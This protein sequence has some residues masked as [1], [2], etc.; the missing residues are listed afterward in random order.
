MS[1]TL[2]KMFASQNRKCPQKN[3]RACFCAKC[4]LPSI[5][6]IILWIC[7]WACTDSP[8]KSGSRWDTTIFLWKFKTKKPMT[9]KTET[10]K[11]HL[12]STKALIRSLLLS[13]RSF[14]WT[15]NEVI[16][17]IFFYPHITGNESKFNL[18]IH[19]WWVVSA[20]YSIGHVKLACLRLKL[21]IGVLSISTGHQA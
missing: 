6:H 11:N 1:L 21:G 20:K 12:T 3:I 16:T 8:V 10:H 2:R 9:F 5:Y 13:T 18:K 15:I 7:V 19:A 17:N 4:T 14:L